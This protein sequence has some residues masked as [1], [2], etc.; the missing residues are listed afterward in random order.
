METTY[1]E[2]DSPDKH[3]SDVLE[4]IPSNVILYK[5]L[6]GIGATYSEIKAQRH[7]IIIEPN[8]PV[9]IGKCNS[10]KH[11]NDNLLGVYE[12]VTTDRIIKYLGASRGNI[13]RYSL[14][15]KASR[16]LKMRF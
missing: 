15:P 5:T 12:G 16:R 2:I 14:H 9:I 7:S 10:D 3:L 1:I 11:K 6:T 4:E 13:I 8:V